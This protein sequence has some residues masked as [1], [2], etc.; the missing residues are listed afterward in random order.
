MNFFKKGGNEADDEMLKRVTSLLRLH[1]LETAELIHQ[2]HL[3]RAQSQETNQ[4]DQDLGVLTIKA[5]F[6]DLVLRVEIMNGRNLKTKNGSGKLC[7]SEP[8]STMQRNN[9][10]AMSKS[11][12][13]K[14]PVSDSLTQ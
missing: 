5:H 2:F 11:D 1:G 13:L 9:K 6:I 3:D 14:I 7:L 10:Q 4:A 12:I 8:K